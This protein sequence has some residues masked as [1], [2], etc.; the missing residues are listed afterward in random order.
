MGTSKARKKVLREY[1]KWRY[2]HKVWQ[3]RDCGIAIQFEAHHYRC[4]KC[5]KK[6]QE[7]K[8]A[9]NPGYQ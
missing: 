3:C 5:W 4:H 2:L 9:N 6:H 1:A 8:I 7:M